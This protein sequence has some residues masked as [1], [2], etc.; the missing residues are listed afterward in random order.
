MKLTVDG[1]LHGANQPPQG[2]F[3]LIKDSLF[4][5][6]KNDRLDEIKRGSPKDEGG[7]Q[8]YPIRLVFKTPSGGLERWDLRFYKDDFGQWAVESPPN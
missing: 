4:G 5:D 3:A 8:I 2:F 7:K 6:S 1:K